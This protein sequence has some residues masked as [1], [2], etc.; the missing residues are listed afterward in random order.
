MQLLIA[1]HAET[2]WN[3]EHRIQGWTDSKLT[4]TGTLQARSLAE[5]LRKKRLAAIYCSDLGRAITTSECI[6]LWHGK[7][8]IPMQEFRE[9]SWGDWEGMTADE[10][11]VKYPDDWSKFRSRDQTQAQESVETDSVTHVPGGETIAQ[12]SE[13]LNRGL[14][15]V[16]A[17]HED[18]TDPVLIVGHGGSLRFLLTRALGIGPSYAKRFHIDN[19]SLSELHFSPTAVPVIHMLNDVSH[20]MCQTP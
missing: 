2:L 3:V 19:T 7:D 4:A 9:T 8:P 18:A 10:I 14:D 17:K 12:A 11:A 15:S 13:R 6:A 16:L 1:R 20:L 5:R